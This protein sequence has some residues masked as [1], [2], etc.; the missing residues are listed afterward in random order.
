MSKLDSYTLPD[1]LFQPPA[2]IRALQETLLRET[3]DL[4]HRFSPFY[5]KLMQREGL[6]PRHIQTLDDLKR[7]PPTTKKEF[8]A[9]PES[10]RL[11]GEGLPDEAIIWK[12]IYSSGTTSGRPAP[13]Y[14]AALDHQA[15]MFGATRRREFMDIYPTDIIANLF[16]LT[17]FP[18]GAYSRCWDEAS[19]TGAA[20]FSANTGRQHGIFPLNHGLDHA[21]RLIEQ[22]KATILWGVAGYVRRVLVRAA[23][24]GADL[25]S[26]RTCLITGEASS[27]AM[28]NDMRRRMKELGCA[29]A[30]IVNR[31]GS[32]EQGVSMVECEEG[33]GFHVLSPDQAYLEVLDEKGQRIEGGGRGSLAFTNL[34]RRGTLFLRYQV[35]DTITL[36]YDACPHCGRTCPRVVSQPVRSGEIIKIKGMLVNVQ[37]IK[38]QLEEWPDVIEYQIVLRPSDPDDPYSMDDLAIRLAVRD[39]RRAAVAQEVTER[40]I[41]IGK[42]KPSI[43]FAEPNDIYDPSL[44]AKAPRFVDQ[45]PARV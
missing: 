45:R 28:R 37:N 15:Y 11:Q 20:I 23:E 22:H 43:E 24:L 40:V 4:A 8:L 30:R 36:S 14:V 35:G 12:V 31:Y 44:T 21:L 16:P 10:F 19:A 25:R 13:I 9:D 7:L 34:L 29:G 33:T 5:R 2:K 39:E 42:V 1:I 38:D 18:M 6:E 17:P 26:V 32:A 3:I 41:A 27:L